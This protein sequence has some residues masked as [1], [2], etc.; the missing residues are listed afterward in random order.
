MTRI[1]LGLAL[2]TF[3]L[4][5]A[6]AGTSGVR[7]VALTVAPARLA[8]RGSEGASVRVRN[9]GTK[10]V[11][12]DVTPAG[13]ALDLRGRPHIVRGGPRSAA[14]WLTL[15]P[16]HFTVGPHATARLRVSARLPQ[17]AEPGDHDAL[18]LFTA[19]PLSGA[20]VAVRLRLGVVVVVRTPGAIVR[21][22]EPRRLRVVAR[23]GKRALEL[24][25]V[26]EGNV[27]EALR[28]V[29]TVLSRAPSGGPIATLVAST[30]ELRPQTR[31]L[32]EFRLRA[33]ARG[34]VMARVVVPAEPGRAVIRR[35]FRLRL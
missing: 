18:A 26:N 3:T 17:H 19:R 5:P 24:D 30:R 2:A 16:A 12:V 20:E 35:T 11:A 32:L 7:P 23:S 28:R 22:L 6:S 29:R 13:F 31:G 9:S 25:V 21:R 14:G 33:R 10:R 15:R 4:V 27:T 1:A 34:P 8:L